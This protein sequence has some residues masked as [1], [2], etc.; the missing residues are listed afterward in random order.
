MRQPLAAGLLAPG[1]DDDD[2]D[3]G[4]NPLTQVMHVNELFSSSL[5]MKFNH[6]SSVTSEE[7]AAAAAAAGR[8]RPLLSSF[9]FL[10]HP[11]CFLLS[12][13]PTVSY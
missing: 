1:D 2:D 13:L 4:Q 11:P 8:P 5:F 9:L 10:F 6:D 12:N 7:G 3:D